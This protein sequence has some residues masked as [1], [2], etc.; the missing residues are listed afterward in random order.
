M[1]LFDFFGPFNAGRIAFG[2]LIA[3]TTLGNGASRRAHNIVEGVLFALFFL[4]LD[5]LNRH[6]WY[7]GA[8]RCLHIDFGRQGALVLNLQVL[9][10]LLAE[11]DTAEVNLRVLDLD[12][13]LLARA[14]QRDVDP[15]GFRQ[16][17]EHRVD[18]LVQLWRERDRDGRGQARRHASRRGVLNHEEVLDLVLE[19]QQLKGAERERYISHEDGLRVGDA[20]REVLEDDFV[21]LRN[22]C[23]AFEFAARHHLRLHDALF[24][25]NSSFLHVLLL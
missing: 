5:V 9:S 1:L 3:V 11:D 19:G 10:V 14:N 18:V 8:V 23:S 15:A 17:G 4:L 22:K 7:R 13:S 25:A 20:D 2:S 6:E 16:D 12:E 24:L 21:G